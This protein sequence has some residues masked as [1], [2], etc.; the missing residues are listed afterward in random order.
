MPTYAAIKREFPGAIA[1]DRFVAS[2]RERLAPLGF[3]AENTIACVGVCRD[4]L[5]RPLI[6]DIGDAWG[7]AFNFSSLA[8][9]LTLGR[10]GFAAARSHAPHFDG[11]ERFVF[12]TTPHVGIDGDGTLGRVQR[13]GQPAPTPACGALIALADELHAGAL[14]TELDPDDI[15]QSLLRRRLDGLLEPN[16]TVGQITHI[17]RR[18]I[19]QD[20]E[21]MIAGVDMTYVDYAVFSGVQ[22]HTPE[23]DLV[24]PAEAYAVVRGERHELPPVTPDPA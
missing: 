8:G 21:H 17:A 11:R 14:S 4:E 5:A 10:T 16:A 24:W 2:T 19:L 20:L 18:A 12:I 3:D 23:G 9:L 13:R 15:E 22:I 1:E 6:G 7:E